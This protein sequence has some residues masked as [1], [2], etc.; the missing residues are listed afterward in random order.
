MIN[1]I[2]F[3]LPRYNYNYPLKNENKQQNS[4]S[5]IGISNVYYTPISFKGAESVEDKLLAIEELHCPVCGAQTISREKY[6]ELKNTPVP[7]V[8]DLV[9]LLHENES[10]IPEKLKDI[11]IMFDKINEKNPE[12]PTHIGLGLLHKNLNYHEERKILRIH[13]FVTKFAYE[14]QLNE[15]DR[16]LVKNVHETIASFKD[17]EIDYNPCKS[18]VTEIILSMENPNKTKLCA[19]VREFLKEVMMQRF[20]MSVKN[21]R[22]IPSEDRVGIFISK[23]FIN[24]VRDIQRLRSETSK[25][26]EEP[27]AVCSGCKTSRT[28]IIDTSLDN[29]RAAENFAQYFKD[30]YASPNFDDDLK[31]HVL[32]VKYAAEIISKNNVNMA[33]ITSPEFE[34]I[35]NNLFYSESIAAKFDLANEEDI[36]CAGCNKPT[37]NY[38]KKMRIRDEIARAENIYDLQNIIHKYSYH[39]KDM[40]LEAY[41]YFDRILNDNPQITEDEMIAQLRAIYNEKLENSFIKMAFLATEMLNDPQASIFDRELCGNYLRATDDKYS[42]VDDIVHVD[43][44]FEIFSSTLANVQDKDKKSEFFDIKE[45]LWQNSMI[46]SLLNPPVEYSRD[47]NSALRDVINFTVAKASTSVDHVV[48]KSKGGPDDIKN[49]MILCNDCNK[50][51]KS[52]KFGHWISKDQEIAINMQKYLDAVSKIIKEKKLEK[53]Y[54]YPKKFSNHIRALTNRRLVLKFSNDKK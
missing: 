35:K 24:S 48:P 38:E 27:V 42:D 8:R 41:K 6:E 23:L 16:N 40:Y 28:S 13:K 46:Q 22:E 44:Y 32:M 50:H 34:D 11:V 5:S 52:K 29:T 25:F 45:D 33:R 4:Q 19:N 21:V 3:I 37:I 17:K 26:N 47:E 53:Y 10:Y 15:N 7:V 49:L 30:I 9:N 43:E 12:L 31:K 36:P 20:C 18:K 1:K 39:F 2:G 14:N 54:S 51:K